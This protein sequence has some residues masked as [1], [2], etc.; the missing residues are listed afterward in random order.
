MST[1]EFYDFYFNLD[2]KQ[3][4]PTWRE[5]GCGTDPIKQPGVPL[6]PPHHCCSTQLPRHHFLCSPTDQL[7]LWRHQRHGCSESLWSLGELK[8]FQSLHL[9]CVIHSPTEEL[10]GPPPA[11]L[12]TFHSFY[13]TVNKFLKRSWGVCAFLGTVRVTRFIKG[14]CG[15]NSE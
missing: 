10:Q 12:T 13:C 8:G 3:Q 14:H 6:S 1:S 7:L 15:G 5:E 9:V 11:L 2:E 4:E